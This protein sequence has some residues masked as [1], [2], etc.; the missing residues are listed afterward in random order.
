MAGPRRPDWSSTP[1]SDERGVLRSLLA[2]VHLVV[3]LALL[4]S[5]VVGAILVGPTLVDE[6]ESQPSPI[7]FEDPPPAGD[8][9]PTLTDPGDPNESTYDVS[10]GT[11]S[12]A[13]VED[14]VHDEVNERRAER[15][16]EP[17]EWDGTIA[18]VSRAHSADMHDREYFDHT[19]PDDDGPIDRFD[20]VG[21]YC[22]A[23]GENLAMTWADRNVRADNGEVHRHES[24]EELAEGVVDQWMNSPPHRD[25]ML[26]DTWDRGGV[27]VYLT[28]EGQVFA[29]HNFCETP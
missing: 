17:I 12:S 3:V 6:F 25:A 16:L 29:T 20:E 19:N 10:T 26:G 28:D 2:L 14:F 4:V 5:V 22:R 13:T 8:R 24:P 27:G 15:G 7:G 9:D 21:D 23:Y 18:S 1:S 11:F